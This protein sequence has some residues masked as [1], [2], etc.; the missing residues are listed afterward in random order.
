MK[1][2]LLLLKANE[3]NAAHLRHV[4][5]IYE[6]RSR[7]QKINKD[8]SS[9]LFCKNTM[10]QNK[11]NFNYANS[12]VDTGI[13]HGEIQEQFICILKGETLETHSRVQGEIVIQ[14]LQGNFD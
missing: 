11:K 9:I 5:Q 2:T 1:T 3:E 10:A 14:G 4:L 13:L 8:H 7:G 12:G 6:T